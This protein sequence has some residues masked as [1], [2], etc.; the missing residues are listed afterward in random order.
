[1][2]LPRLC[3]GTRRQRS[4]LGSEESQNPAMSASISAHRGDLPR[5][6]HVEAAGRA[7]GVATRC[8][9]FLRLVETEARGVHVASFNLPQT[10]A[11][12]VCCLF[13]AACLLLLIRSFVSI[14]VLFSVQTVLG[15]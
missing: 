13:M 1:M 6:P 8:F 11:F 2:L 10:F 14:L 3:H 5:A 7:L 4:G 9:G 12:S 15:L